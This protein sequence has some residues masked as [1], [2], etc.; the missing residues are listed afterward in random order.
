MSDAEFRTQGQLT[1][2]L[3]RNNK[4]WIL[5]AAY[6]E[7]FGKPQLVPVLGVVWELSERSQLST[8]FPLLKYE[9]LADE[10]TKYNFAIQP[11]GAQWTWEKGDVGNQEPGN[12]ELSAIQFS[13]GTQ[14]EFS[15]KYSGSFALGL[16][17]NRKIKVSR[18]SDTSINASVDLKNAWMAQAG[19]E[20]P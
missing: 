10:K 13:G 5:G 3:P 14:I 20:F 1:F 7:Q 2:V 12:I 15:E 17:T 9:Y 11:V 18:Q 8:L 19:L 6:G 16:F 4:Q